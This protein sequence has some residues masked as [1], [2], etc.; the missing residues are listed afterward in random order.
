MSD[1]LSLRTTV[2]QIFTHFLEFRYGGLSLFLQYQSH[3][4]CLP[5][6]FSF[7]E[8]MASQ[9]AWPSNTQIG[10]K[11]G[12]F[13]AVASWRQCELSLGL[14]GAWNSGISEVFISSRQ[15]RVS[16]SQLGLA[17]DS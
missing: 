10:L 11:A 13:W 17:Q 16:E 8:T 3:V 6:Y 9:L 12:C 14:G 4:N 5:D 1:P 7:S 2:A 15:R